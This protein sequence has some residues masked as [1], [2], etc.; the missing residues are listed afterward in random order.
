MI[1]VPGSSF[2]IRSAIW[3]P[4]IL[5]IRTS[6]STI[7][8]RSSRA[9]L[10]PCMPSSSNSTWL[11]PR[12]S[13][14]RLS[15]IPHGSVF[16]HQ[17]SEVSSIIIHPFLK[18]SDLYTISIPIQLLYQEIINL[19]RKWT[20][21]DIRYIL[22]KTAGRRERQGERKN[23]AWIAGAVMMAGMLFP[24]FLPEQPV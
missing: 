15:R 4:F 19:Q 18:G 20:K 13:R 7:S 11:M 14:P 1:L 22:G 23:W 12:L 6:V 3:T 9:V 5:G 21:Y 17:Q 2:K 10:R 24:V 16:H 8:G